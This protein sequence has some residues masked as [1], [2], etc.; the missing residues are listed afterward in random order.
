[1]NYDHSQK[2]Y[3]VW[4]NQI[5]TRESDEYHGIFSETDKKE[6]GEERL[7]ELLKKAA[8]YGFKPDIISAFKWTGKPIDQWNAKIY[9]NSITQKIHYFS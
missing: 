4:T 2:E 7:P 9:T 5:M 3:D 6:I 8:S 1:M